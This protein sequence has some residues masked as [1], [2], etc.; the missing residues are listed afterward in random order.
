MG[1]LNESGVSSVLGKERVAQVEEQIRSL[2]LATDITR[3]QEFL[4][5][6]KVETR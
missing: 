5:Q 6:L 4:S 3:Q 2:V 1:C